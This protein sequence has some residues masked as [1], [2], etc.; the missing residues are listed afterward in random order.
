M[1]YEPT[2][3]TTG[4]VITAAKL[5]KIESG[6]ANASMIVHILPHGQRDAI[7]DKTWAEI[8]NASTAAPIIAVMVTTGDP[9]D[10]VRF[11]AVDDVFYDNDD[12]VVS[13]NEQWFSAS[14]ADD[15]PINIIQ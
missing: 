3:W 6:I 4:D 15:Y 8:Y 7:L 14:S 5:N 12:Y 11:F 1:S 2:T 10:R 13:I 9:Y